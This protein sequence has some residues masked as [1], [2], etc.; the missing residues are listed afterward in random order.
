M[1]T[2]FTC[3]RAIGNLWN[4]C[5]GVNIWS[6]SHFVVFIGNITFLKAL[7]INYQSS[8]R[9]YTPSKVSLFS[10]FF[11]IVLGLD[12]LLNSIKYF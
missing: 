1:L 3:A 8:W 2:V 9:T 4:V 12:L 11:S 6:P 10:S 7:G 5:L